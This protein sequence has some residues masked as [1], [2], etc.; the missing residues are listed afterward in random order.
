MDNTG[1]RNYSQA[2]YSQQNQTKVGKRISKEDLLRYIELNKESLKNAKYVDLNSASEEETL[3]IIEKSQNSVLSEIKYLPPNLASIFNITTNKYLHTGCLKTM[4]IKSGKSQTHIQVSF[5]SSILTCLYPQFSTITT[6]NQ[7]SFIARLLERLK[8][9]AGGAKFVQFGYKKKYQWV[10]EDLAA[11][12]AKGTYESNVIKYISDYF[13][14]NIFI[15][16]LVKDLLLFG[17]DNYVPYKQ[18]IFLLKYEDSTYEPVFCGIFRVFTIES[19]IIKT[20]RSNPD[21]VTL[22]QISNKVALGFEESEEDLLQ[23]LPPKEKVKEKIEKP[24]ERADRE[25]REKA[26]KEAAKEKEKPKVIA[27]VNDD[28]ES[29][30]G[31]SEGDINDNESNADII[32]LC[33]DNENNENNENDETE[34]EKPKKIT[35]SKKNTSTS[36]TQGTSKYK[37]SDIKSTLKLDELKVIAKSLNIYVDKKTKAVL[38]EDIKAALNKTK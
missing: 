3:N 13:H 30:N 14:I 7:M 12:V 29:L 15:L 34:D 32:K 33:P 38:I 1:Q 24:E 26:A 22:M 5:L 37:L 2:N 16:D 6:V 31:F 27:K 11:D 19:Q 25:K 35:K 10:K 21:V 23:Y 8:I 17:G 28:C 20:I 9:E 4:N 18:T 36:S